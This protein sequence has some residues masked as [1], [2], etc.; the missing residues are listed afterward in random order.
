M[1]QYKQCDDFEQP[2][3]IA[4][5][6]GAFVFEQ[7][8]NGEETARVVGATSRQL[9]RISSQDLEIVYAPQHDGLHGGA[10][11][12]GAAGYTVLHLSAYRDLKDWPVYQTNY[13]Y[14]LE[15]SGLL[16]A[17]DTYGMNYRD[18]VEQP[19]T[20]Q[21]LANILGRENFERGVIRGGDQSRFGVVGEEEFAAL[22]AFLIGKA[23]EAA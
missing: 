2:P 4:E 14:I 11:Y 12:A 16:L 21:A 7:L 3:H 15:E 9:G 20:P 1:A 18:G 17:R 5:A 23:I 10:R 22:G 13:T 8:D 6:F 19:G